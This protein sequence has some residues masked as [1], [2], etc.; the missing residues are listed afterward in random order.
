MTGISARV[1][2][3][4]KAMGGA[5]AVAALTGTTVAGPVQ[6]AD[7]APWAVRTVQ[8]PREDRYIAFARGY[9]SHFSSSL[10]DWR[11][12]R[13]GEVN[14][15]PQLGWTICGY[16]GALG[17]D[18]PDGKHSYGTTYSSV[19]T[20]CSVIAFFDFPG[21]TSRYANQ[22]RFPAKWR[23]NH[24]NNDTWQGLGTIVD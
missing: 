24:T 15:V 1:V 14:L 18:S 22:T 10:E 11:D 21:H 3:A 16:Q 5:V 12:F 8:V 17:W 9:V 13:V 19:N 2:G 23:S 7:A 20:G 4:R 6:P